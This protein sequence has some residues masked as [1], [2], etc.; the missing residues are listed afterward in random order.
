MSGRRCP[1][2]RVLVPSL[3]A[4]WLLAAN[5][6]ILMAQSTESLTLADCIQR[7]F[8][9]NHDLRQAAA[10]ADQSRG[11]YVGS[12]ANVLPNV[13]ASIGKSQNTSQRSSF[14]VGGQG[15]ETGGEVRSVDTR[16]NF[17]VSL[18]QNLLNFSDFYA[19]RQ[20]RR[21]WAGAQAGL[22]SSGQDIAL[23]VVTKFYEVV[24]NARNVELREESL[25]LSRD[26]MSRTEALFE[27]G[28]VPKADVLESRVSVSINQR[29]LIGAENAYTISVADLNL[30]VGLPIE[31]ETAIQYDPVTIPGAPDMDEALRTARAQRPDLEESQLAVEAARLGK[32]SAWWQTLPSLTGRLFFS[33]GTEEPDD[34]YDFSSMDDL[35]REGVWGYSLNVSI[36][37]FDG[38]ITKGQKIRAAA[39]ERANQEALDK[40]EREI[41]LDVRRALL[42][43]AAARASLDVSADEIA[44]AE[45]R[46]RLREAMYDHGASTILELIQARVDLTN[47]R[48]DAI[49]N[50]TALQ[51]AWHQYLKAIGINLRTGT[52]FGQ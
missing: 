21:S 26:Q 13:S 35:R 48:F 27:L 17:D 1:I 20:S 34:A 6:G 29:D 7:A 12:W 9:Y 16:Y 52:P 14:S 28:A 10:T 49:S 11:A 30:A 38:F 2:R 3:V 43:I 32:R 22:Q 45:E 41:V 33:K 24:K 42:D 18:S 40:K 5:P 23:D 8:E 44:S 15:F 31:A 4:A 25:Q 19:F 51:L 36:P 47:A 39:T 37:I 50:E 46:L